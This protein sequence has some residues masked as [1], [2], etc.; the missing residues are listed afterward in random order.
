MTA[1]EIAYAIQENRK[2]AMFFL[3]RNAEGDCQKAA[4]CLKWSE[5]LM[6]QVSEDPNHF[7][8]I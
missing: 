6:A 3:E 1:N 2:M 8:N 5:E 7:D 4:E